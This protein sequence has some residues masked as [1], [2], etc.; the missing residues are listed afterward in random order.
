M[1]MKPRLETDFE[2]REL[3]GPT[4]HRKHPARETTRS[5]SRRRQDLAVDPLAEDRD[6]SIPGNVLNGSGADQPKERRIAGRRLLASNVSDRDWVNRNHVTAIGKMMGVSEDQLVEARNVL[7]LLGDPLRHALLRKAAQRSW[8][9]RDLA[10]NLNVRS[11][12]IATRAR[13]LLTVG[14]LRVGR[15]GLSAA[16]SSKLKSIRRYIDVLVTMAAYSQGS[17]NP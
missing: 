6:N 2:P 16:E 14:A 17:E 10:Y 13:S 5:N 11:Q 9:S 15:G 12:D 8:C 3:A 1:A 7:N 4:R